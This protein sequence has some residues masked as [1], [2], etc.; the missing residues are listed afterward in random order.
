MLFT[1]DIKKDVRLNKDVLEGG[2]SSGASGVSLGMRD[3]MYY[4]SPFMNNTSSSLP[5]DDMWSDRLFMTPFETRVDNTV[6][7]IGINVTVASAGQL[8]HLGIYSS[9]AEGLPGDLLLD[10]G[11]I[12]CSTTGEKEIVLEQSLKGGELY[13]LA[14]NCTSGAVMFKGY[15][16]AFF[17]TMGAANSYLNSTAPFSDIGIIAE[18]PL[19][20]VFPG[21]KVA[22]SAWSIAAGW[23]L[24][25]LRKVTV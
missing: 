12:D 21:F 8:C 18:D 5:N 1:K 25:W 19:P 24:I 16:V 17:S 10:A 13:W 3:D 23:P 14:G 11:F 15:D 2:S 22:G 9:N 4:V 7:R 6:N 20:A